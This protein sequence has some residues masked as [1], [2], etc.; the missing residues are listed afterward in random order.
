MTVPE[1]QSFV[2]SALIAVLVALAA[3]GCS[4]APSDGAVSAGEP[5]KAEL[6]EMAQ[7]GTRD[8][9]VTLDAVGTAYASGLVDI[10][11]QVD[12]TLVEAPFVEGDPV[13]E[14]QVLLRLDDSKARASVALVQA[15]LDSAKAK[16]S[17]AT[18]RLGR[19]RK[20]AAEDLVS[21]EEFSTLESEQKAAAAAVREHE[22]EVRLA[23]RN[24]ED[25]TLKAPISGKVGIRRVDTGNYIES[26][27]VVTTIVATDPLEVLFTVPSKSMAGLHVGQPAQIRDTD[28]ARTV[29]ASGR[30]RVIDPRVDTETRM[31]SVKALVPNADGK[32]QAG[33]FVG[34]TLV[35]EHR[36]NAVVVPEDAV[37]PYAGK[38]FLF[39]VEGDRASR[40]EI[41]LGERLPEVVEVVS[42]LK[43]GE[44]IVT[45]GQHRL[46]EG[47]RVEQH[48]GAPAA[49]RDTPAPPESSAGTD[50][51]EG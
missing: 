31:V 4:D 2:V 10:R 37:I 28:A 5:E 29:I 22:A 50:G 42:G 36:E 34:I 14:G 11:P 3:A 7:V 8:F 9:D 19:A 20:L 39:V 26:G 46:T 43:A 12:G 48:Q 18:E 33:Q 41:V 38:T 13:S 1:R 47:V 49:S 30:I 15:Q 25:Y 24:L 40:R 27:T 17:V 35:R 45:R 21:R 51:A 32:L 16:L 23:E 6:V 44:T